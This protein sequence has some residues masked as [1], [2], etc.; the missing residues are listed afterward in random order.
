MMSGAHVEEVPLV[1]DR[2][3]R[4]LGTVVLRDLKRL[5]ERPEGLD[6]SLDAHVAEDEQRRGDRRLAERRIGR[7]EEGDAD[8]GLDAIAEQVDDLDV[9]V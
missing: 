5:G 1:L 8:L 4:A 9:E 3:E 2:N 7:D 6:V